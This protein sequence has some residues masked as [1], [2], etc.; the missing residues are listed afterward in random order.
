M[1]YSSFPADFA[2]NPNLDGVVIS[3]KYFGSIGTVASPYNKG[4][5]TT[6]EVGHWLNLYHIWGNSSSSS[7]SVDDLVTDTPNQYSYNFSCPNFPTTDACTASSPGIMF[8][9]YMDYTDDAC[10]NMFTNGQITRMRAL[11]DSSN[12]IRRQILELADYII[13]PPVISGGNPICSSNSQNYVVSGAPSGFYWD[14]NSFLSIYGSNTNSTV[15]L[16][17]A[18]SISNGDGMVC[19][20]SSSGVILAKKYVWVGPPIISSISGPTYFQAGYNSQ[21]YYANFSGGQPSLYNTSDY[22]WLLN[23]DIYD[24][25]SYGYYANAYFYNAS[26]YYLSVRAQNTCG[27]GSK[28]NLIVF[29]YD[30]SPSPPYPNPTSDVLNVE[31]GQSSSSKSQGESITYDIRLYDG[32]GNLLRQT[33]SK[34]GTVQFSVSNLPDGIYYLHIYDGVNSKPEMQQIVVEH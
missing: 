16:N 30:Y 19:I 18:N 29:A 20:K 7:C 17:V 14:V 1:G 6:Q 10:M 24:I 5:T 13:T 8:M 9:N 4:R 31:L 2:S 27:W 12:G 15:N 26:S 33:S 3:Y 34:G 25:Y 22:E 21:T 32:Q 23:H 11:F 28:A